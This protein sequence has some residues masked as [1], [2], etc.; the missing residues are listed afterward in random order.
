[1]PKVSVIVPVYNVEKYI[2]KCVDSLVNQ[3]LKDIEI[4]LVDDGSPDNCGKICDEYAKKDTRI[5]V[6]HKKNAGVSAARNDG[7]D[8]SKSDYVM[9]VDSDDWCNPNMCEIAYNTV[10]D[11]KADISI[12]TNYYSYSNYEEVPTTVPKKLLLENYD[13]IEKLQLTV[14]HRGYIKLID[15]NANYGGITAPWGKIFSLKLIREN[16]IKFNLNVNGLFDDG[17]FVMETLERAKLVSFD[18]IPVYHYRILDNSIVRSFNKNKLNTYN[19]IYLEIKKFISKYDKKDLFLEAYYAR[20][21]LYFIVSLQTYFFNKYN[22]ENLIKKLKELKITMNSTVY[23]EAI[24][25]VSLK[26]LAKSQRMYVRFARTGV[27][28]LIWLLYELKTSYDKFKHRD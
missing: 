2:H 21:I 28:S 18:N 5:K 8:N 6:I 19:N 11:T 23:K 13:N 1:M 9:F 4:I 27:A 3:T 24:K 22:K 15:Q 17:L 26:Y 20:V 25:N 10:M 12:F 16:E 7:I 14:L